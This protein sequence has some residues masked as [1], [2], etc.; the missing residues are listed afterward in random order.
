MIY[1][2]KIKI[3]FYQFEWHEMKEMERGIVFF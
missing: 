1:H 2:E 3:F